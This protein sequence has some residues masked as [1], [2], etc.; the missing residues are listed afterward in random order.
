MDATQ[1]KNYVVRSAADKQR[2]GHTTMNTGDGQL[3]FSNATLDALTR[4]LEKFVQRPIV[5]EAA[6]R[7]RYD[8]F[9]TWDPLGED[10]PNPASVIRAV[11]EQLG[12]ELKAD[13][14]EVEIVLVESAKIR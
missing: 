4:T 9:L 10:P 8:V 13:K 1:L 5:S 12:F 6:S 14:R 7:E 11:K 3:A 2:E